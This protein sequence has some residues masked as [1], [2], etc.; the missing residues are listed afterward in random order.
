MQ[1][2]DELKSPSTHTLVGSIAEGTRPLL[3]VYV[4]H[5]KPFGWVLPPVGVHCMP[6]VCELSAGVGPDRHPATIKRSQADNPFG[7]VCP[8]IAQGPAAQRH[9]VDL[10]HARVLLVARCSHLGVILCC[11]L[12]GSNRFG[13]LL[14]TSILC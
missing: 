14:S 9:T 2:P 8:G 7:L 5:T 3:Q 4:L 11:S 6:K 12:A 1:L 10:M 13:N